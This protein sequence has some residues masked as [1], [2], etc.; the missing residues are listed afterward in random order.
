MKGVNTG[1]RALAQQA[2]CSPALVSRKLRDGKTPD[3]IIAE[4]AE[5]RE[6]LA[7]RNQN[8][9]ELP[10]A[11]DVAALRGE[12]GGKGES[13]EPEKYSDAVR[14]KEI[15]LA[16][17]RELELAEKRG[18]LV[19]ATDAALRIAEICQMV[20]DAM[21]SIPTKIAPRLAS[22]SSEREIT[23]ELRQ[24]IRQELARISEQLK[25]EEDD[26]AA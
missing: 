17:L 2:G 22:M 16:D 15:A 12:L 18:E 19:S 20:R 3:Q 25:P 21:V 6:R 13:G 26:A 24:V 4:A 14:R 10:P 23:A 7:T 1:V 5:Y 9:G 11:A 8:N